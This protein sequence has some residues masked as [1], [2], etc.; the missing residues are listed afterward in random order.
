MEKCCSWKSA[1]AKT[2]CATALLCGGYDYPPSGYELPLRCH[3]GM[4]LEPEGASC[5]GTL[6]FT[7]SGLQL[8]ISPETVARDPCKK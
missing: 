5:A 8:K 1:A 4:Q 6:I 7:A 2:A 3:A